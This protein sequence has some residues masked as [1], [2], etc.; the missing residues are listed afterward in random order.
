MIATNAA[1]NKC[2]L[3]PKGTGKLNDIIANIPAANT[4]SNGIYFSS[5]CSLL[6]FAERY[7]KI[8]A[9]T[10]KTIQSGI[11]IKPSGICNFKSPFHVFI[12]K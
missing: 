10:Y 3:E 7:M 9:I 2:P 11:E 8:I 12:L 5:K 6:H 1:P 4:A